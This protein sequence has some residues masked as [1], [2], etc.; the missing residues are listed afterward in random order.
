LK[1]STVH[2]LKVSRNSVS[3]KLSAHTTQNRRVRNRSTTWP[4]WNR[5]GNVSRGGATANWLNESPDS[6]YHYAS[7]V[8]ID[9][10]GMVLSCCC[11]AQSQTAVTSARVTRLDEIVKAVNQVGA[12]PGDLVAILEAL[13]EAGALRDIVRELQPVR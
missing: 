5:A 4:N 2:V 11:D 9:H 10:R 3:V 8:F 7:T 12:A 13:K 1:K 6:C